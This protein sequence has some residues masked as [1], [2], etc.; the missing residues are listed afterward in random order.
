[1]PSEAEARARYVRLAEVTERVLRRLDDVPAMYT[2]AYPAH[3]GNVFGWRFQLASVP[4]E[5]LSQRWW[6]WDREV[7]AL[8]DRHPSVALR[9]AIA[10]ASERYR[11]ESWPAG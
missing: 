6:L 10:D 9:E 8:M 1:M 5:R 7:R 2:L 3:A 11:S 4:S